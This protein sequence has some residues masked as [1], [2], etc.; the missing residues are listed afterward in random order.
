[1]PSALPAP[2]P[3]ALLTQWTPQPLVIAVAVLVAVWYLRAARR[4]RPPV[5]H[6][7]GPD[8]TGP[9]GPARAHS[10]RQAEGHAPDGPA[11]GR[12]PVRHTIVF[13]LGLATLIWA[14]CG[15]FGAYS[16]SLFW[17]WVSKAL[18]VWLVAPAILLSGQPLRLARADGR[19]HRALGSLPVRIFGSPFVAPAT[20]P[21]LSAVLFFGPVPTWAVQ[22]PVFGWALDL[23]LLLLGTVALVPLLGPDRAE[24]SLGFAVALIFGMIEL[25]LDAVPGIVMRLSTHPVT[26]FWEYRAMHS[27]SPAPVSDQSRA[28]AILWMIAE[29]IDLPFLWMA[30]RKWHRLDAKEAAEVDAVLEAERAARQALSPEPGAE[31]DRDAPWW[32]ADPQMRERFQRRG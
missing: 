25:T 22:A 10:Q 3:S 30:F 4:W 27:W 16:T 11:G 31:P 23:V 9:D 12:W 6:G 2:T 19:M 1:M 14:T 8:G 18:T 28:G 7:Q 29:G 17:A 26:G 24:T 20:V 32:L 21:L 15:G 13:L 5:A